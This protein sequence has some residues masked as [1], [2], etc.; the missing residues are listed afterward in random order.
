MREEKIIEKWEKESYEKG[1]RDGRRELIEEIEKI[2]EKL[3][4]EPKEKWKI[5]SKKYVKKGGEKYGEDL[6]YWEG[7]L[8]AY[9]K[10]SEKL[11]GDLEKS[12][13]MRSK[14]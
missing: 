7:H 13:N 8:Q 9:D 14:I 4:E 5:F 1:W 2:I 3:S 10:V 12:N 6:S 11:K